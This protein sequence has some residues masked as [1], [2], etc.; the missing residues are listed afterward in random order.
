MGLA[1]VLEVA[2]FLPE[3]AEVQRFAVLK[4]TFPKLTLFAADGSRG[5][6]VNLRTVDPFTGT[7]GAPESFGTLPLDDAPVPPGYSRIVVQRDDGA[8]AEITRFFV[9]RSTPYVIPVWFRPPA[10]IEADM[11]PIAGGRF[12]LG[13]PDK[14]QEGQEP[15]FGPRDFD[16]ADFFIDRTEVGNDVYRRFMDDLAQLSPPIMVHR[17]DVW[18]DPWDPEW[19]R[20]PVTDVSVE[21]AALFA[22]WAGKRLPTAPE[23]ERAAR[24]P[25]LRLFPWGNEP[26]LLKSVGN[27]ERPSP[28]ENT[29]EALRADFRKNAQPVDV[30]EPEA[31]GPEGL[32][33]TIGNV[34]EWTESPALY[35]V[36]GRP[37]AL[38]YHWQTK[39]YNFYAIYPNAERQGLTTQNQYP[40]PATNSTLGF[41][42]AKSKVP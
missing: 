34:E 37:C 41:R 36:D 8:F 42:C 20:L 14:V 25:E 29:P 32:F 31:I 23:W 2:P 28:P 40:Q 24:G 27:V 35:V 19:D 15:V 4:E 7:L 39:G 3:D 21:E 6:R 16:I 11:R 13:R 26:G 17:P 10:E 33:H 5:A 9:D 18:P 30:T 22:E 1:G 38:P 12:K